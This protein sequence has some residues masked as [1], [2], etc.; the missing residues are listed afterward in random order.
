MLGVLSLS[1]KERQ[2]AYVGDAVSGEIL[3]TVFDM[4]EDELTNL[5]DL[6]A[7]MEMVS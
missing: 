5:A 2:P 4:D 7:L 1:K 3:E 6:E